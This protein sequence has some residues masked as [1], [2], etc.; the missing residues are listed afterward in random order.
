MS[1]ISLR[2]S[3]R[4]GGMLMVGGSDTEGKPGEIDEKSLVYRKKLRQG[5]EG[6]RVS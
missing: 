1:V 6:G 2:D 5:T 3:F 4:K